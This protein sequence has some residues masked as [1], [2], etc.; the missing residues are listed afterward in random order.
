M[1][2]PVSKT[3][4][5]NFNIIIESVIFFYLF[6]L[7]EIKLFFDYVMTSFYLIRVFFITSYRISKN[8][9]IAWCCQM[10]F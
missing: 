6:I 3:I 2:Y 9:V 4:Q 8:C 10:K 7:I 1:K 5:E